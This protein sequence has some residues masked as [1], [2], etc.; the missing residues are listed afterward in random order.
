MA[1]QHTPVVYLKQGHS[2]KGKD[3]FPVVLS[4]KHLA[5]TEE[6]PTEAD[7]ASVSKKYPLGSYSDPE[8]KVELKKLTGYSVD[9]ILQAAGLESGR[10]EYLLALHCVVLQAN[11]MGAPEGSMISRAVAEHQIKPQNSKKRVS[12]PKAFI[13]LVSSMLV[14]PCSFI[15][16]WFTKLAEGINSLGPFL[17]AL[18]PFYACHFNHTCFAP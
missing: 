2:L 12:R 11:E 4:L 18:W 9:D 8:L 13:L 3:T 14:P 15:L 10:Q 5:P 7:L 1:M 17:E 16:L 6:R